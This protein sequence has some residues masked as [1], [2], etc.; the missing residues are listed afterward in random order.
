[1]CAGELGRA[2]RLVIV[3]PGRVK[4]APPDG[5]PFVL[6]GRKEYILVA[7]D[8][9]ERALWLRALAHNKAFPACRLVT[10]SS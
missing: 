9:A 2:D 6:S 10:R 5:F 3:E 8:R 7:A 4:A 1:M